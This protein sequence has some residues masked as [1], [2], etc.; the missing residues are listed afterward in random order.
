MPIV[1]KAKKNETTSDVIKKFKKAVSATN[2]VQVARDRAYFQKP[3]QVKAVK[4]HVIKRAQ[5]RL[6]SLKRRKNANPSLMTRL[7]E[8]IH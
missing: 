1:I 6:R 2:V 7:L 4:K 3:S 5:R 8:I